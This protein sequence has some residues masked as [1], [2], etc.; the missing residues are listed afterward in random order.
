MS[1]LGYTSSSPNK[2]PFLNIQQIDF[3]RDNFFQKL[4]EDADPIP[5][6]KP[7]ECKN[8]SEKKAGKVFGTLKLANLTL[9]GSRNDGYNGRLSKELPQFEQFYPALHKNHEITQKIFSSDR[10]VVYKCIDLAD[11][12]TKVL[13]VVSGKKGGNGNNEAEILALMSRTVEEGVPK[14]YDH[15]K[16]E[17]KTYIKME[18]CESDL[19]SK[20]KEMRKEGKIWSEEEIYRI[21]DDLVPTLERLHSHGYVHLD[22]KP[23]KICLI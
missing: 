2:S 14:Y 4:E 20:M 19:G 9:L 16:H 11:R 5:S 13:K 10:S 3:F 7:E 15:W 17:G 18:D 22:I 8:G 23:G 6:L 21:F 1:L 12:Q